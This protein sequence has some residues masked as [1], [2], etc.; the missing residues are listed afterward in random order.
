MFIG[1]FVYALPNAPVFLST[2][3]PSSRRRETGDFERK[4]GSVNRKAVNGFKA[5]VAD[6]ATKRKPSR[7]QKKW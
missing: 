4:T 3:R 7:R 2:K 5:I 1:L 6:I